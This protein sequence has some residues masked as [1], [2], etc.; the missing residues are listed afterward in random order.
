[1]RGLIGRPRATGLAAVVA[2]MIAC[3]ASGA[4]GAA[5]ATPGGAELSTQGVVTLLARRH[6][7]IW[8]L[9][10]NDVQVREARSPDGSARLVWV[11]G[12]TKQ[13]PT[14][15]LHAFGLLRRQ[16]TGER[17]VFV[18]LTALVDTGYPSYTLMPVE[19]LPGG[20][21][22]FAVA[23]PSDAERPQAA[24]Y[25]FDPSR[26][27][28]EAS[29]VRVLAATGDLITMDRES[30]GNLRVQ[31]GVFDFG[32]RVPAVFV[33]SDSAR[34]DPV[35]RPARAVAVTTYRWDP[36]RRA[37]AVEASPPELTPFGVAEAFVA[38]VRRGDMQQA[39]ALTTA[40]WRRVMGVETPQR[41]RAYLQ[42]TR[43]HLLMS[44]GPFRFLGG[45]TGREAA[46][47]LFTDPD[48]RIYRIRLRLVRGQA[49]ELLVMEGALTAELRGPWQVD[50][51]DGGS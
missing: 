20:P 26:A 39:L 41:L 47:I 1:M 8:R 49:P 30:G 28:G 35:G 36:G 4:S 33:V 15:A 27:G 42:A 16:P 51:L 2:A 13:D 19:A 7:W 21:V 14:R 32:E 40:E 50:G 38:A 34:L 9:S 31:V 29:N 23:A 3:I 24:L 45:T 44:P 6:E 17:D 46:S 25:L 37:F 43:P 12:R 48:G 22:F 11:S 10:P 18:D 5:A